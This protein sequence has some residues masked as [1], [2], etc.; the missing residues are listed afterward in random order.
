MINL[1]HNSLVARCIPIE[2]QHATLS[3][4][5][6]TNS[7]TKDATNSLKALASLVL[8]RNTQR[9]QSETHSHVFFR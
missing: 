3:Q 7:A 1:D 2:A 9:N 6:A 4:F 8:K 5:D